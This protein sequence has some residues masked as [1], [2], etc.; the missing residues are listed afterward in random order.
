MKKSVSTRLPKELVAKVDKICDNRSNLI[1]SALIEYI[2]DPELIKN[3]IEREKKERQDLIKRK[4]EI[5]NEI[6]E[7]RDEIRELESLKTEMK[8][9]NKVKNQIP[10]KKLDR[11]RNAVRSNKYD[12]DHRAMKVSQVLNHNAKKISEEEGIEE[13]KVKQVLRVVTEV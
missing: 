8:T 6:E 7:K 4:H 9:F 13:D 12:G 3:E 5:D 10:N 2:A 11:V 1:A